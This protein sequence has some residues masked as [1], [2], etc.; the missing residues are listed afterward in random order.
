MLL[1]A[2]A[3]IIPVLSLLVWGL[4]LDEV[5]LELGPQL[6]NSAW[7]SGNEQEFARWSEY[8]ASTPGV[9]VSVASE[10]DVAVTV[11]YCIK[12]DIQFFAQSG[13]HGFTT[14]LDVPPDGI[15]INLRQLNSITFNE[16]KTEV[17]LGGGVLIS[18]VIEAAASKNTLV[19]TGNCN[20]VGAIGAIIGGGYGNLMGIYGYG[21]DNILSLDVVS[22]NGALQTVTD[23][24]DLFWAVRGAGPNFGIITSVVMKA[25]P[26]EP[27]GLYAWLGA[28]TFIG[29]KIEA[30]TKAISELTLKPE[31]NVLVYFLDARAPS[32]SPTIVVTPFY[33]G[34]EA[35]GRAAFA[36]LLDIGPTL[37]TT[38]STHYT[39]WN[40]GSESSC[41]KGA[42]KPS[43]CAGLA[44]ITP[45]TWKQAWDEYV[46]WVSSNDGQARNSTVILEAYSMDKVHSFSINSSSVPWRGQIKFNAL[47]VPWYMDKSLD[48][49]AESYGL[50]S[51][52]L[53]LSTSGLNP[54]ATYVNFAFGDEEP[55]EIYGHQLP[56]L[57]RL[58][59]K[60]DPNNIFDQSFHIEPKH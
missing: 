14:T 28:L 58:K 26:V 52:N 41:I 27:T 40:D 55:S 54:P 15:L 47:V 35:E 13:A 21:V 39:H 6:S 51:R 29:D 18:E 44:K 20:C 24:D 59:A 33:Y 11:Q 46:T 34:S 5:R 30:V 22:G 50:L 16:D 60:Y 49:A 7:I 19:A 8:Y 10:E 17:T 32:K 43:Y 1:S 36:S 9:V 57:Q 48:P 42:R 25:Y 4:S 12:Y 3:L 23:G 56:R 38:A 45:E 37:D 53:I 2:F 31:M